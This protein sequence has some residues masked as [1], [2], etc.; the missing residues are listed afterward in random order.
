MPCPRIRLVVIVILPALVIALGTVAQGQATRPAPPDDADV[1]AL[2]D[3]LA[4]DDWAER[5]DAQAR[6]AAMAEAAEP[7]LRRASRDSKDA[8]VAARCDAAL[9]QICEDRLIGATPITLRGDAITPQAAVAEIARQ[10][11]LALEPKDPNL[12]HRDLAPLSLE[13]ERRPFWEVMRE[14]RAQCGLDVEP[15]GTR[16]AIVSVPPARLSQQTSV[17]GPFRVRPARIARAAAIDLA[18]GAGGVSEFTFTVMVQAEPK[19][20]ITRGS[21]L[22]RLDVAEDED[23][24]S[25]LPPADEVSVSLANR[26][27]TGDSMRPGITWWPATARLVVAGGGAGGAGWG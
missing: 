5:H 11:N 25:L 13:L 6:L 21:R 17:S 2:L 23:G 10:M 4:S 18:S 24:V 20:N 15:S 19:L 14:L 3:K 7:T 9:A 27:T 16:L 1:R 8:E 22:A 26:M 12:W